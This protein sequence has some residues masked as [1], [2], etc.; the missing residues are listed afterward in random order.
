MVRK[1]SVLIVDR[2]ADSRAVLR[3]ALEKRGTSILE[4]SCTEQGLELARR[5]SPSV[6]V[7]DLEV[8]P[9]QGAEIY[10]R[11]ASGSTGPDPALVVL[12]TAQLCET[13]MEGAS[14]NRQFV[15]KPYH[16]A[17]LIRKIEQ[18]LA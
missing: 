5:H 7:L 8:E 12:G 11:F 15:A 14:P 17:P 10:G 16:Y 4:A 18:L 9:E 1:P 2:S 6:I 13:P 3:T